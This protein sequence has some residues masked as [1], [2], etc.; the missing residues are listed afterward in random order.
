MERGHELA[1]QYGVTSYLAPVFDMEHVPGA[2]LPITREGHERQV[3]KTP[4]STVMGY[5]PALTP[6]GLANSP[7][8]QHAMPQPQ[9]A[10]GE[11][12]MMPP[13]VYPPGMYYAQPHYDVS[14]SNHGAT[15]G[16]ALGP[17]ADIGMGLPPSH[18]DV[19]I[20]QYGQPHSTHPT[21]QSQYGMIDDMAPPAKR[22]RSDEGDFANGDNDGDFLP[23]EEA[24]DDGLFEEEDSEDEELRNAPPLPNSF[25]MSTKPL[26]PKPSGQTHQ[27]RQD[28]LKAFSDTADIVDLR[29]ILGIASDADKID[30]DIDM[31]IDDQGH[32]ALHWA[33][34]LAKMSLIHQLL[35]LG[36]DIHRG[37]YAG[38][39]ALIRSVLTTN[40]SEAGSFA[41]LLSELSESIRTLDHAQR[42]IVH[43]I[44]L[45]AGVKGRAASA[46]VYMMAV[47]DWVAKEASAEG[48]TTVGLKT[49]VDVQDV[50]GDTALNIAARVGSKALIQL[51][52]GAGADKAKANKLG[53]KPA[54]FGVEVEV[55]C[56]G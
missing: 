3:L 34:A 48:S 17:A 30:I 56:T 39:T 6:G 20:D 23:E 44:A 37:N 25:R 31:V 29:A 42:S 33:T 8:G 14:K 43:H 10:N 54:D 28:I 13:G 2:A 47:L 15:L 26:R 27:T 9:Y 46:R 38:E 16:N 45:I 35:D 12:M 50:Y 40:H 49:L 55:S 32:T 1:A 21:Y 24:Q 36:A 4:S 41:E 18:S 53:L 51:L 22:L 19:Y 52:L 11:G 7:Y 5:N